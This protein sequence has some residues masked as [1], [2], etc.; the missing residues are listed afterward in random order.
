MYLEIYRMF[1]FSRERLE[2]IDD[3]I[4][5]LFIKTTKNNSKMSAAAIKFKLAN[6]TI[7]A[8]NITIV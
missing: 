5:Y 1:L 6:I 8:I 7:I 4:N 3:L 2:I